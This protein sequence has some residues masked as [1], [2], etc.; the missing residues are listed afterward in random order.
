MTALAAPAKCVPITPESASKLDDTEIENT[1]QFLKT[2]LLNK[3]QYLFC[4]FYSVGGVTATKAA[5]SAG[6]ASSSG[7]TNNTTIQDCTVLLREQ[8]N[9]MAHV[10][11]TWRKL[12]LKEIA[13][14]AFTAEQYSAATGAIRALNDMDTD[15]KI[16]LT[17]EHGIN[18]MLAKLNINPEQ[19]L[20]LLGK[21]FHTINLS[22]EDFSVIDD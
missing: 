7:L 17:L 8:L 13:E 6:Y 19:D 20:G 14:A 16:Q 9:R 4:E 11:R 5:Q 15:E 1:L 3:K 22:E 10:T 18:I 21:L 2:I 12:K